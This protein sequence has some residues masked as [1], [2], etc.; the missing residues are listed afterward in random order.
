[1]NILE[2]KI[3]GIQNACN[4]IVDNC[5]KLAE[6]N[7]N[8]GT[9][10]ILNRTGINLASIINETADLPSPKQEPKVKKKKKYDRY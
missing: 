1:M 6:S 2:I 10:S 5:K 4:Q 8:E 7:N 9:I 3:N